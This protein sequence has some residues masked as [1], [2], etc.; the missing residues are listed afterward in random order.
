[1][2]GTTTELWYK[3]FW[4]SETGTYDNAEAREICSTNGGTLASLATQDE[5]DFVFSNQFLDS[6][7]W[8]FTDWFW[9]GAFSDSNDSTAFKWIQ[10]SN[11]QANQAVDL[12]FITW[13]SGYSRVSIYSSL[14][15]VTTFLR[16]R[17]LKKLNFK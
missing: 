10:G 7:G 8:S 16:D 11:L 9:I 14:K 12:S 6:Q 3:L 5:S 4:G 17:S 2:A 15:T 1:M 13:K